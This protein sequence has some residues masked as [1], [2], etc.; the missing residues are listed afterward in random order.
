MPIWVLRVT[1]KLGLR[2]C[3]VSVNCRNSKKSTPS[4]IP[5]L[6]CMIHTTKIHVSFLRGRGKATRRNWNVT[7]VV[8]YFWRG[9]C[10]WVCCVASGLGNSCVCCVL[11]V[12]MG[13][14][15]AKERSCL[16]GCILSVHPYPP[17]IFIGFQDTPQNPSYVGN[18]NQNRLC[19][20]TLDFVFDKKGF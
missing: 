10:V 13:Y 20:Q 2:Y 5:N 6:V 19:E 12:M 7:S 9:S 18:H 1:K 15:A 16:F 8:A 11:C 4:T 17:L 14:T 3:S